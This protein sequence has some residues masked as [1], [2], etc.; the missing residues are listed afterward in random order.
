MSTFKRKVLHL[1]GFDPRGAR[2]YHELLAEQVAA[3]N[4]AG[5]APTLLLGERGR[6][7]KDAAW[8]V[9]TADES[10]TTDIR[11]LVWD[12][13]VRLHWVKGTGAL[14]RHMAGAYR[15]FWRA[16]EW[17][18]TGEVPRG[19]KV[20]LV[21]PGLTMLLAPLACALALWGLLALALHMAGI[22]GWW[23]FPVAAVAGVFAGLALVKRIHSLWLMRFIIFND[24]LARGKTDPK[25]DERLDRFADA[26]AQALGEDHDEV[27]F[28]THSN[29][30]ILAM[31]VM[32]RL[33]EKRGA[34]PAHFALVTLGSSIPLVSFRRDAP[35]YHA[36][37]DRVAQASFRWLDLGS[38][39]DG[40]AIPL[41]PPL[42][43]RPVQA[44]QGLVQLSPRWFR[45]CDPATYKLRRRNKYLTHFDYLR[46]LDRPSPL[47]YL[48]LAC[49]N[50][51]LAA[52]IAA[53]EAE[54]A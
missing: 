8:R 4:A 53:F 5:L 10:C 47:D 26:I 43:G 42:L 9:T 34:L 19:S 49:A 6:E 16:G 14:L 24:Q 20:A 48:G 40:A 30:S 17:A 18:I 35:A 52:S 25:L 33:L 41:V 32:A 23:G 11:F 45:Y 3:H 1:G 51:P 36:A 50:R 44:P 29:G 15:R 37:C 22:S 21:Y 46:R 39:T 28:V 13:L 2:F 7:G 38:L 54:N 31:P 12:D 27:L